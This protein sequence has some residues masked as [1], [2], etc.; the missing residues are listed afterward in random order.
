MSNSVENKEF[1]LKI[2]NNLVENL[3]NKEVENIPML[4]IITTRFIN[5]NSDVASSFDELQKNFE[6][7]IKELRS[8]KFQW[9]DFTPEEIKKKLLIFNHIFNA[10]IETISSYKLYLLDTAFIKRF[11]NLEFISIST[12]F[13]NYSFGDP[14]YN[15]TLNFYTN[16]IFFFN[17]FYLEQDLLHVEKI[18][19]NNIEQ[20]SVF[21]RHSVRTNNR[22]NLLLNKKYLTQ[23]FNINSFAL[24]CIS[25]FIP[26]ATWRW[27]VS[28]KPAEGIPRGGGYL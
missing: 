21:Y 24:K 5:S 1:F 13:P 7:D 22:K 8:N 15:T 20:M 16:L 11:I 27:I 2:T 28:S 12:N 4:N 18:F 10:N 17:K 25:N 14:I 23:T 6:Q 26:G 9:S 19:S 3:E